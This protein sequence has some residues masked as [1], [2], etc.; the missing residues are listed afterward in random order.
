MR[1]EDKI[2]IVKTI[3]KNKKVVI[4]FS[5]GADSTLISYLASKVSKDV[6]AITINNN[7]MPTNFVENTQKLAKLFNKKEILR[8]NIR[9]LK[10]SLFHKSSRKYNLKTVKYFKLENE[11]MYI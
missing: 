4:G 6:L 11:Q 10:K 2:N 7:L 9:C 1:I 5:G 8:K 3:L